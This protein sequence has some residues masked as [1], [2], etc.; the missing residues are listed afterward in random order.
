MNE[1]L[2]ELELVCDRCDTLHPP[3]TSICASCNTPFV[4]QT[5]H[6]SL[7]DR[8][9]AFQG[10]KAELMVLRGAIAQGTLLPIPPEGAAIGRSEGDHLLPDPSLA[11]LA[12][13]F[14]YREGH[15]HVRDEGPLTSSGIYVPIEGQV[16]L[17]PGDTFALG[18]HLLRHGGIISS[19]HDRENERIHGSPLPS[20][21]P[22][23]RLET[24]LFGGAV[25]R[26]H[27]LP[28]PIRIGRREGEVILRD[29]RFVS[30]RHCALYWDGSKV[31]LE[32]LQ[33]S[34]GVFIRMRPGQWRPLRRGETLRMGRNILRVK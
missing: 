23:L 15:L 6:P 26:V 16:V 21:T 20:A 9:D 30:A 2:A 14:T 31:L 33:S 28:F 8:L 19:P 7:L 29:D 13:T 12:A 10:E 18:D 22:L 5:R 11:P 3:R 25:G 32:D 34:N 17:E 4:A 1:L 24:L 27:L